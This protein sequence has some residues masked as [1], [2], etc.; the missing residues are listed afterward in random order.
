[1]Y[2]DCAICQE[3]CNACV[4]YKLDCGHIFH[5]ECI[6]SWFR[7]GNST[8]PCCRDEKPSFNILSNY[9]YL[10][11]LSKMDSCPRFI[12][13]SIADLDLIRKEIKE[14]RDEINSL[15]CCTDVYNT[16]KLKVDRRK[17]MLRSKE[18]MLK[19]AKKTLCASNIFIVPI[20]KKI[21][22]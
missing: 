4:N 8:C 7:S 13:D 17:R 5:T 15:E 3:K 21:F 10:R 18:K 12:K 16:I 2:M 20:K 9:T 19:E 6:M 22:I 14:I 1:M 11:R